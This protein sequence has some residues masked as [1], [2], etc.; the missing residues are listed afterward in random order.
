MEK[1]A[2]TLSR[3]D[4]K[5][6]AQ[7][8]YDKLEDSG[9]VINPDYYNSFKTK[10]SDEIDNT[11]ASTTIR[12]EIEPA[13]REIRGLTHPTFKDLEKAKLKLSSAKTS[14]VE[15]VRSAANKISNEIDDMIAGLQPFHVIKGSVDDVKSSIDQAKGYWSRHAQM[16]TI[17]YMKRDAKFS[18][19]EVM[20]DDYDK[21][22]RDVSRP[23]VTSDRKQLGLDEKVVT[24]LEDMIE[25]DMGKNFA[26]MLAKMNPG[27][28]TGRGPAAVATGIAAGILAESQSPGSG[29]LTGG[30]TAIVP[31]LAGI[32]GRK[33]ASKITRTELE[34]IERLIINKDQPTLEKVIQKLMHTGV[35]DAASIAAGGNIENLMEAAERYPPEGNTNP[36]NL[37]DMMMP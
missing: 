27:E 1:V 17:D 34:E 37:R 36:T 5:K 32:I 35:N 16:E 10:L 29:I 4:L 18:E 22:M 31:M 14:P 7:H 13:L 8:F 3:S 19:A 30:I 21:A 2:K 9:F 20:Y 24:K 12:T 6:K 11:G 23:V 28:A 33:R 26:R 15:G 25:G